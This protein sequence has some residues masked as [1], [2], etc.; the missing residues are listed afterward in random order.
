MESCAH[1]YKMIGFVFRYDIYIP[2]RKKERGK[3]NTH[4]S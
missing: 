2:G 1:G 4:E 3:A